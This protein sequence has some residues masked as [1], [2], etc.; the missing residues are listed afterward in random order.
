MKSVLKGKYKKRYEE[1]DSY[2]TLLLDNIDS[3]I[4]NDIM[5]D[6]Y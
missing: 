5:M 6:I 4:R 3:N 1:V 2:C